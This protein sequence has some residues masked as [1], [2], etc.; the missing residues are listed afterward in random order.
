[1]MFFW[2]VYSSKSPEKYIS[3]QNIKQHNI[4]IIIE[5]FLKDHV[6]L[7]TGVMMQDYLHHNYASLKKK[8]WIWL[9]Y[10]IFDQ[11]NSALLSVRDFF[12]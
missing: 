12:Q 6:T 9:F 5:W 2:M 1:M 4:I 11:I 10:C 7:K 8:L 3:F